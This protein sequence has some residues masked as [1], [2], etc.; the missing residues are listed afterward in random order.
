[1]ILS[2]L[3]D[4][5]R[6]RNQVTLSDIAL[7]FDSDP[8]TLRPMLDVWLRKGLIHKQLATASCGSSCTQCDSAATEI[9]VWG[10]A[11]SISTALLPDGCKHS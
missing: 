1:M 3:R 6:Q 8:D 9:Y 7:H 4:Y 11:P 5:V 2:E 10:E